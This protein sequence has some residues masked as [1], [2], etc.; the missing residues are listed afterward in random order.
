MTA[1]ELTVLILLGLVALTVASL[2]WWNRRGHR[3]TAEL[4]A[5]LSAAL[6][7]WALDHRWQPAPAPPEPAV[8]QRVTVRSL[9]PLAAT[10]GLVDHL[11]VVLSL[12]SAGQSHLGSPVKFR[13]LVWVGTACLDRVASA[14]MFG[15]GT[16]SA[17]GSVRSAGDVLVTSQTNRMAAVPRVLATRRASYPWGPTRIPLWPTDRLPADPDR[18]ATLAAELDRLAGFLLIEGTEVSVSIPAGTPSAT[19]AAASLDDLLGTLQLAV[20]SLRN[21]P[22]HSA[23]PH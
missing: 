20:A 7:T 17:A 8:A 12:W 13:S 18:W 23:Q 15:M 16:L 19:A 3:R 10:S 9:R 22:G 11:P 1:P 2:L 21:V 6:D 14:Q 4:G 5:V